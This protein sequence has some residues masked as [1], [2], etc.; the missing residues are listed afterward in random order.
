MG[1]TKGTLFAFITLAIAAPCSG[2]GSTSGSLAV[3]ATI[4]NNC[5]VSTSP[6]A[7][8]TYDPIVANSSTGA[9]VVAAGTLVVNCTKNAGTGGGNAVSIS[10]GFGQNATSSPR[11][12]KN[13]SL[14]TLSYDLYVPALAAGE[15]TDCTTLTTIWNTTNVLSPA[16]SFWQGTAHNISVCGK[17]P[18][19]QTSASVGSYSDTVN[20]TVNF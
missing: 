3:S 1:R 14:D 6:V 2:A 16:S 19:G 8:G 5:T 7:F 15:Y 4:N 11:K 20:V 10:L 9:D 12:M 13:V 18:K 17:V